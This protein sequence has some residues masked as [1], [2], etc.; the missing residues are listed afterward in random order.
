MN[1][2]FDDETDRNIAFRILKVLIL[3]AISPVKKR[4]VAKDIAQ[5][6]LYRI[7]ELESSINYQYIRDILERLHKEGAYIS[8]D[9]GIT[10]LEDHFHI[11]LEADISLL[12]K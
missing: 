1:S 4:L 6:L 11:S 8:M 10:P 9:K 12:V 7:T 2:I 5:M 3:M